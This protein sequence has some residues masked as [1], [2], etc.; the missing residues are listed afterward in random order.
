MQCGR[1]NNAGTPGKVQLVLQ[2]LLVKWVALYVEKGHV[3]H[4]GLPRHAAQHLGRWMLVEEHHLAAPGQRCWAWPCAG[5]RHTASQGWLYKTGAS[6]LHH[7]WQWRVQAS[8]DDSSLC[9]HA[10]PETGQRPFSSQFGECKAQMQ[11]NKNGQHTPCEEMVQGRQ[12]SSSLLTNCL[13]AC[14][15]S[16]SPCSPRSQGAQSAATSV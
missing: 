15:K 10:H 1:L 6:S 5:P 13:P 4:P 2:L 14:Q 3:L 12:G 7:T 16:A 11:S 9:I 8:V